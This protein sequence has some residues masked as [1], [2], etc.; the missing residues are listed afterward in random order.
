MVGILNHY[1]IVKL[2]GPATCHRPGSSSSSP[3]LRQASCLGTGPDQKEAPSCYF[4]GRRPVPSWVF[5][6]QVEVCD[7]EPSQANVRQIPATNQTQTTSQRRAMSQK[8]KWHFDHWNWFANLI[9]QPMYLASADT[10]DLPCGE[11]AI[12]TIRSDPKL[13]QWLTLE[14]ANSN[15]PP[16]ARYIG[17]KIGVTWHYQCWIYT[18][19]HLDW[20]LFS[21]IKRSTQKHVEFQTKTQTTLCGPNIRLRLDIF[22]SKLK[23]IM[24]G[25][26]SRIFSHTLNP[27]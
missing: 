17:T 27:K 16:D 22:R 23:A 5:H 21:K 24:R 19:T 12:G 14:T 2:P 18:Q 15:V 1:F 20:N 3:S 9:W 8:P 25:E 10:L 6:K 11:Q 26:L 7:I 4:P 13:F